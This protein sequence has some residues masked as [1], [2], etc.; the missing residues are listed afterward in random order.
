LA[1]LVFDN[2]GGI[3][4]PTVTTG[5][6]LTLT[7]GI[8]ASSQNVSTLPVINGTLDFAG[9]ARTL[10]I[11]AIS[12]HAVTLT[13]LQP[14]L[15]IAGVIRTPESSRSAV[16][17]IGLTVIARPVPASNGHIRN[18]VQ[19]RPDRSHLFAWRRSPGTRHADRR[20]SRHRGEL[21]ECDGDLRH[22]GPPLFVPLLFKTR[23]VS[24][25]CPASSRRPGPFMVTT[26]AGLI[27]PG[28]YV[29]SVAAL[30]VI[31]PA[32]SEAVDPI[33]TQPRL[34]TKPPALVLAP[35]KIT[36]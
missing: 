5:G 26:F 9:A 15:D 16:T 30:S 22:P 3:A 32:G 24:E 6:I 34:T 19:F 4:A 29:V 17:R 18:P 21:F 12:Y 33:S 13:K 35:F 11:N 31:P 36:T 28:A 1:A 2:F 7:G 25:F 10:T 23:P 27:T 8:T 14:T 20:S